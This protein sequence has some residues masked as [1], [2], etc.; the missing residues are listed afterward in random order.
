MRFVLLFLAVCGIVV[1]SLALHVHYSTDLQPCSINEKWDCGIVNHSRFAV[2]GHVPV[3]VIGIGGYLILG[4][5]AL[6]GRYRLLVAASLAG[7]A[8]SLYL[9]NIEANQ[10]RVWCLYCVISQGIIALLT[11]FAV[12]AAIWGRKSAAIPSRV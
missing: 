11:L 5:L 6:L 4:L 7:L 2:M 10:L 3:A 12:G 1:S 8:F 9:T